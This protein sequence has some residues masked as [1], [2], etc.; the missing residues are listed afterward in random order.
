[1]NFEPNVGDMDRMA[2]FVLAAVLIVVGFLF[3]AAPLSYV[4]YVIAIILIATGATRRCGLYT[5]AG[6]NTMEKKA[7]G[8]KK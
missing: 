2:R 1:M 8:S 6:I 7:A 4:A 3:L 5:V